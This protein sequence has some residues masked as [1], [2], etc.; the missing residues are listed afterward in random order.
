ML[1]PNSRVYR[2]IDDK[3]VVEVKTITEVDWDR[4][5][6]TFPT[7]TTELYTYKKNDIVI[8]TVLITYQSAAKNVILLME[9]TR[10]D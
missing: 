3:K 10:F 9:K 1:I 2:T 5:E 4:I 6:T 7:T 8:Q